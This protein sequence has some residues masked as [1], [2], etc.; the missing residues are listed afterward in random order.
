MRFGSMRT[1]GFRWRVERA[2]GLGVLEWGKGKKVARSDVQTPH[3]HFR[4]CG[5]ASLTSDDHFLGA[6]TMP[7]FCLSVRC[8]AG[9]GSL[10]SNTSS[11]LALGMTNWFGEAGKSL[12]F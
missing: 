6:V 5:G 2:G 11:A 1:A 3:A 8:R 4:T 12:S 10:M 7:P 9:P